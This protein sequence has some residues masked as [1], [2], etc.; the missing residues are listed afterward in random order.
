M[1]DDYHI[2]TTSIEI[3]GTPSATEVPTIGSTA[4]NQKSVA[5]GA[6]I[7]TILGVLLLLICLFLF[8]R[9][10]KQQNH[11]QGS[12]SP[13]PEAFVES[14]Y[15]DPSTEK[16]PIDPIISSPPSNPPR[17]SLVVE[18]VILPESRPQSIL[19]AAPTYKTRATRVS[20]RESRGSNSGLFTGFAGRVSGPRPNGGQRP[21]DMM[22]IHS[23]TTYYSQGPPEYVSV[24]GG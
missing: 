24:A 3:A 5:I 7:G 13:Q 16:L 15:S 18:P 20:G 12:Q 17:S 14:Q 11:D 22:S 8:L 19:S 4:K 6:A 1:T 21:V 10:R 9:R 2:S 23:S